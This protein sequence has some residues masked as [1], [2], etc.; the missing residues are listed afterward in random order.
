MRKFYTIAAVLVSANLHLSTISIAQTQFIAA[1]GDHSVFICSGD[2][3]MTCGYNAYGQ[4]GDGTTTANQN[5]VQVNSLSGIVAVAAGQN[6]TLFL[7]NDSTVWA[8]GRNYF[9]ELGNGTTTVNN[10]NSIPIQ[11]NSLTNIKAIAAGGQHSLFLKSDGTVWA[12]GRNNEGQL[13]DGTTADKVSPVQLTSLNGIIAII[14]GWS[15]SLFL[16]N[17]GTVWACGR[18]AEGQLGDGTTIQRNIPVQVTSLS[19]VI[20]I[21]AGRDHSLFLKNNNTVW[22][23][24]GNSNGQLGDGTVIQKNTPVQVSNL[25]GIVAIAAGMG[26]ISSFGSPGSHSLFLKNDGTAWACGNNYSGQL[27]DGTTADKYIPTQVINLTGINAIAAGGSNNPFSTGHSLFLRNDGTV[28]A[29]GANMSGQLGDGTSTNRSTPVQV[30]GLCQI[31]LA[32]EP[33]ITTGNISFSNVSLTSMTVAVVPGNGL[34]RIVVAKQ[35]GFVNNTP[36]DSLFYTASNVFG[37]GDDLGSGNYVVYNGTGNTFNLTGLTPDTKYHFASYEYNG[38]TFTKNNYLQ[39]SPAIAMQGTLNSEPAVQPSAIVFTNVTDSSMT[40]SWTNGDGANRIVIARTAA[41]NAAPDDAIEYT[42]NSIFAMGDDLGLNNYIVYSGPSNTFD[43]TGLTPNTTYY[44]AIYEYNGDN[45]SNNYLTFSPATAF[46]STLYAEPL[47][48]AT[49]LTLSPITNGITT[50]SWTNGTGS[51]RVVVVREGLPLN[52]L[53]DDGNG[54]LANSTFALGDNL[55]SANY[56]C[57][58]GNGNSFNLQGLDPTHV[59]YVGVLEYNGS[60]T[61]ANYLTSNFPIASNLPAQPT[62]AASALTITPNSSTSASVYWTNGNGQ[63]RLLVVKAGS[64]V[65]ETPVDGTVY[66]ANAS[67][68]SGAQLGTGNFAVY[69]GTANNTIVTNLDSN[70]TYHFALFE[71]NKDQ[72]GPPN[73]LETPNLTGIYAYN[74]LGIKKAAEQPVFTI[75]PNPTTGKCTINYANSN[76]KPTIEIFNMLGVQVMNLSAKEDIDLTR[77]GKGIYTVKVYDE[78]KCYTKR[79]IVQ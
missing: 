52:E 10:P 67:Y 78:S 37:S 62:M 63:Y 43:L 76:K 53:P 5:S 55:G 69:S 45:T 1:G 3:S 16:K 25:T 77:F 57:F 20:S 68:S 44:F 14:A 35:G 64:P 6:H 38:S 33:T 49:N 46:K 58:N 12:C 59:Y 39:I 8:C 18:N 71:F 73:Y 42:A 79:I 32:T 24:G 36:M 29:C 51:N 2:G 13:G 48:A 72:V 34:Y 28:W 65:D 74:S 11:V 31:P 17:D 9:G 70:I 66:A 56:I 21:A 15:Y 75:Y 30:A 40:L 61:S 23:C 47:S 19:G 50:V 60:G 54:Y 27:G 41:V 4:L 7:K 26:S 22:A